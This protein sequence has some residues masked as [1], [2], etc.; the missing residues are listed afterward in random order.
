M[1]LFEAEFSKGEDTIIG[2]DVWIGHG[3]IILPG[4]SIGDGAIIG[5]GAVVKGEVPP[6]TV[7]A[8][9]PAKR[10]KRRFDDEIVALLVKLQWW[11][12]PLDEIEKILPVLVSRDFNALREIV[13]KR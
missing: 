10:I 11:D 5:A 2:N 1:P 12:L 3:A 9:N 6:Y 4:T 7:F 13:D 8:G